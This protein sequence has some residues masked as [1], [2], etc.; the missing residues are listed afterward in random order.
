MARP[1]IVVFVPCVGREVRRFWQPKALSCVSV[2]GEVRGTEIVAACRIVDVLANKGANP[3]Y[4]LTLF[5]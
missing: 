4:I 5:L 1:L 3:C 2:V